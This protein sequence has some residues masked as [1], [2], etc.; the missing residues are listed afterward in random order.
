[1]P[2]PE[3]DKAILRDLAGRVAEI[4]HHP[5][6]KERA[7]MWRRHNGLER[8]RPMVLIFPEAAWRDLLPE[9]SLQT[10]DPFCR[11]CE[12]DLRRRLCYWEY[13]RDDSVIEPVI[14]APIMIRNT[15][16]G[17]G[18]KTTVPDEPFG[19][20]HY[21]PVIKTEADI[22]KIRMPTVTPDWEATAVNYERTA[23]I[24][25]GILTVKREGYTRLGAAI[26]DQ[27]A[28]WRGI[29]Q[30]FL[31]MVD[32]PE[33][34]HRVMDRMTRGMLLTLD[35]LEQQNL[36]SLNNGN[37]YVGSGGVGYTDQL[38]QPDFDGEHV[39]LKDMWGFATT[40]IFSE[41]S[42][43]MHDEFALQYEKRY[44]ERFG[45]NCYGCCEPLHKKLD[46]VKTIPNLRRVSMSPF[47]DVEEAAAG[48][49]SGYIFSY[50]PNPSILAMESWHPDLARSV[51]R[52]ALEKTR[53][54]VVELVMKDCHS[55]RGDPRRMSEWVRIARETADEFA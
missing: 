55:C 47:V 5:V 14:T 9:D 15:G 11:R 24:F 48:L 21:E 54:C 16:F 36:L 35:Q 33:W 18:V 20:K 39:R 32:R 37:H 19:A 8:V 12:T 4:G 17:L 27:F 49:G 23:D 28:M 13:L 50:K 25:D 52:D 40:Q 44:L 51:L 6:Q 46:I 31:D 34:L 53:G 7:E 30:M 10:T 26:M 1:M 38:P 42:P 41:V 29:D 43:A 45:L 22:E 3:R 2:V